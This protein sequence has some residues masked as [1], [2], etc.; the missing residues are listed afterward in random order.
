MRLQP[1]GAAREL[2]PYDTELEIHFTAGTTL[3]IDL[4]TRNTGDVP[5]TVGDALHTYFAVSDVR[6]VAVRGLE[7]YPYIDKLDGDTRKRQSGPVTFGAETDRV[8]LDAGGDILIDDPTP[9][10]NIRI[11]RQGSRSTV[12][13][14]PW[15]DKSLRMGDMGDAGYLGMVCVESTNAAEDVVTIAPGDA[16]R[17]RVTYRIENPGQ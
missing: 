16:H 9:G 5:V 11:G 15:I 2:W 17:L 1:G 13:W 10:R 4:V 3:E 8:Y 14:N 12:V 7:D 6:Q